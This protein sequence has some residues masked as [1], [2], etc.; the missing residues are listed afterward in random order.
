MM[1]AAAAPPDARRRLGQPWLT[2]VLIVVL[3]LVNRWLWI[4]QPRSVRWDEADLLILARNLLLGNGY[5]IF[6]LPDL[7]WPPG[8]PL[9]AAAAMEAAAPAATALAIW[10]VLAGALAAGMLYGLSREVTGS[11]RIAA[12]AGLLLAVAPALVVAPLYWGS[13]TESIF[14]AALLAGLWATWRWLRSPGLSSWRAALAAGLAYGASFLVRPEGLVWWALFLAAAALLALWQRSQRAA[15][16]QPPTA[17]QPWRGL[18]T[19]SLAF[20]LLAAPY[21]LYLYQHSGQFLLSGKTGITSVLGQGITELGVSLGNDLGSQLDS[22]GEE[23]LWLSAERFSAGVTGLGDPV[24]TARRLARNLRQI[25]GVLIED[26]VGLAILALVGLGLLARPWDRRR[27][28]AEAFMLASLVPMLV[29]P[30]FYV[31]DRLLAPAVPLLLIWAARGLDG[32]MR[33]AGG[34]LAPWPRARRLSPLAAAMLVIVV[35]ASSLWQQ[36]SIWQAGAAGQFPSHQ[37]AGQWLAVH[38]Q[39]GEAIMTRN[40][41]ISLYAGRPLVALPDAS[42]QQVLDY[43]QARAAHYLVVDSWELAT[44]RPQLGFLAQPAEAPSPLELLAEFS[45]S[46]R[47]TWVYRLHF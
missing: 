16:P 38:S 17:H 46:R 6:Q 40:S 31:Q 1:L 41:E 13:M 39:P 12:L 23:I 35:A 28:A 5:Q 32:L 29:V 14:T 9:L 47:V 10:H 7:T 4:A 19:F 24:E 34:T 36:R 37:V 33:W 22:R 18:A 3:A 30:L 8:A 27:L 45:D 42:W 43:G 15:A 20:L 21:W 11:E 25:P 2:G 44:V 26:L